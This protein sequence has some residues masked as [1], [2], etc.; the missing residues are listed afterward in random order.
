MVCLWNKITI[1]WAHW[2]CDC[3]SILFKN[4]DTYYIYGEVGS[5][6]CIYNQE[7]TQNLL[8]KTLI[9]VKQLLLC[10][11]YESGNLYDKIILIRI[12]CDFVL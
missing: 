8:N 5:I 7:I 3:I 2:F 11:K 9:K 1:I 4:V 10:D 6:L 12:L